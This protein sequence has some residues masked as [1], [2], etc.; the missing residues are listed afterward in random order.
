MSKQFEHNVNITL[1]CSKCGIKHNECQYFINEIEDDQQALK[2][3]FGT[4]EQHEN[5]HFWECDCGA[6]MY[7]L[8]KEE[9]QDERER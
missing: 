7:I 9:C 6:S 4:K 8:N 1:K 5:K 3:E 2:Y